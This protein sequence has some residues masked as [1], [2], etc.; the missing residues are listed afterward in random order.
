MRFLV[1]VNLMNQLDT[2][3]DRIVALMFLKFQMMEFFR[4][5]SHLL[6]LRWV[7]VPHNLGDNDEIRSLT[8]GRMT[9]NSRIVLITKE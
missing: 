6:L 9:I 8:R 3:L 1:F 2:C 7:I 4:S 5:S